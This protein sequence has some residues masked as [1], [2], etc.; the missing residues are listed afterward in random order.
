MA[1]AH[2][3]RITLFGPLTDVVETP[4]FDLELPLPQVARELDVRLRRLVPSLAEHRF[5]LAVDERIVPGHEVITE[6]REIALLPPFAG[7]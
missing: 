5:Q 2:R 3:V 1:Q 7:G 4:E 6:A